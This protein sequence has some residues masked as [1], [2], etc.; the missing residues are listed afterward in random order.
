MKYAVTVILE[1]Y[2]KQTILY[3]QLLVYN[4]FNLCNFS[5]ISFQN[6]TGQLFIQF[7]W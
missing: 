7:F 3:I 4:Y 1:T 5:V 6:F 2:I